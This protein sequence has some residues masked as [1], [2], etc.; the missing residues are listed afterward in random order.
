MYGEIEGIVES[1]GGSIQ[2]GVHNVHI[3]SVTL[4]EIATSGYTGQAFDVTFENNKGETSVRRVFPFKFQPSW[5]DRNGN[6]I[7]EQ[8]QK[9]TYLGKNLHMF[10]NAFGGRQAYEAALAGVIELHQYVNAMQKATKAQ[11]GKEFKI[12]VVAEKGKYP[13]YPWWHGGCAGSLTDELT[14]NSEKHGYKQK[15]ESA[16]EQLNAD[17]TEKEKLPF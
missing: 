16:M 13:K 10:V 2:P 5:T 12:L 11:G 4:E 7:D 3:K 15:E 8:S 1:Q 9:K 17:G 14:F 6:N